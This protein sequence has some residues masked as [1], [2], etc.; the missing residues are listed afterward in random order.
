MP[1]CGN[2]IEGRRGD[3][4]AVVDDNGAIDVHVRGGG[5]AAEVSGR[6]TRGGCAAVGYD[7]AEIDGAERIDRDH[8]TGFR[9]NRVRLVDRVDPAAAGIDDIAAGSCNGDVP[10]APTKGTDAI[11]GIA[12]VCRGCRKLRGNRDI[13]AD[14][15]RNI[16]VCVIVGIDALA[17][18]GGDI[19]A[20]NDHNIA[21]D[22][23]GNIDR[24]AGSSGTVADLDGRRRVAVIVEV[25]AG[26]DRSERVDGHCAERVSINVRRDDRSLVA[27]TDAAAARGDRGATRGRD[28]DIA[29]PVIVSVDAVLGEAGSGRTCGGGDYRG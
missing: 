18:S 1:D 8:G 20:G 26:T 12:A 22:G 27:R 15:D 19:A 5:V 11:G 25:R 17:G 29:G 2:A 3:I 9:G 10:D 6:H 14:V 21:R 13:E 7:A 24:N 28:R 4:G 16:A 23:P